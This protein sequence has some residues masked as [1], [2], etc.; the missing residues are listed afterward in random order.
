MLCFAF[1][2]CERE[3]EPEQVDVVMAIISS[4]ERNLSSLHVVDVLYY[5]SLCLET[6]SCREAAA[7][8]AEQHRSQVTAVHERRSICVSTRRDYFVFAVA[9]RHGACMHSFNIQSLQSLY[10]HTLSLFSFSVSLF[11][12]KLTY[13]NH[14]KRSW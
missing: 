6:P 10:S 14:A 11:P 1:L 12:L 9:Q 4:R 3:R 2:C 7:V 5:Y 13:I 8:D